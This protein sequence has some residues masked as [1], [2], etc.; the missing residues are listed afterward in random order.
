M[1]LPS[2]PQ[3]Q[4][5]YQ[6][7]FNQF[8]AS[9]ALSSLPLQAHSLLGAAM[10]GEGFRIAQWVKEGLR[11]CSLP[12]SRGA[13]LDNLVSILQVTRRV[14]SPATDKKPPVLESDEQLRERAALAMAARSTA[15]PR[16]AWLYHA[17]N[18]EWVI[19]A[20]AY[21]TT[22]IEARIALRIDDSAPV[23][24]VLSAVTSTMETVRPLGTRVIVERALPVSWSAHVRITTGLS[25]GAL[26][27]QTSI[28]TM[29]RM[30]GLGERIGR[31]IS[32]TTIQQ[33]ASH[34]IVPDATSHI[35]FYLALNPSIR[36]VEVILPS[37]KVLIT[38][39]QYPVLDSVTV[40]TQEV[41]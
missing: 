7:I 36:D 6:D 41:F 2:A 5:S 35:G 22:P 40:D 11:A 24:D 3:L 15:G 29:R 27:R 28:E 26:C 18:H 19:D 16:D 39:A 13:N 38:S 8:K 14:V 25:Q 30:S 37:A 12:Y 33:W 31:E 34:Q 4:V 9:V 23:A 17:L 21:M 1:T 20:N 32:L 10:A